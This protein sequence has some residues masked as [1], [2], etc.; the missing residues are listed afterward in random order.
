MCE[1]EKK[2]E[3]HTDKARGY[4]RA[5]GEGGERERVEDQGRRGRVQ[6]VMV[7]RRMT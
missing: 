5:G 4:S 2:V 7:E 3:E 1:S 6:S